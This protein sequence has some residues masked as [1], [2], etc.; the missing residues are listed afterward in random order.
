MLVRAHGV[1]RQHLHARVKT[2]SYD[3][4]ARHRTASDLTD[5]YVTQTGHAGRGAPDVKVTRAALVEAV[6]V[7]SS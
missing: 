5:D 1:A 2:P 4:P 3:A 6:L 7:G